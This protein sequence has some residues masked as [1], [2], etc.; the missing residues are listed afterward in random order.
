MENPIKMDD[1][2]GPP[3]YLETPISSISLGRRVE[4]EE[5]V[6]DKDARKGSSPQRLR[7]HISGYMFFLFTPWSRYMAQSPKR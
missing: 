7:R 3:L 5:Y 1:L 2:G 4:W 6:R